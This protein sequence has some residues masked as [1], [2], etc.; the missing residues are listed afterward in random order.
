MIGY[1]CL[2]LLVA[3]VGSFYIFCK[4][5][6]SY[7]SAKGITGPKP[8]P[9][10]G[11]Y[12]RVFLQKQFVNE[13]INDIYLQ[14]P[15]ERVVGLYRG[16]QPV[17]LV[18]DPQL[19]KQIFIKDF[20]DFQDRDTSTSGNKLSINLFTA[21]GNQWKIMRHKLTPVFTSKK[22][23][24][25]VPLILQ[26]GN[27]FVKYVDYLI[28]N[29]I[30]SEIRSLSGKY[31]LQVIASCAFGLD[32][33]TF[34]DENS[35]FYSMAKKIFSQAP[36][37]R[38]IMILDMIIPGLKRRL[39][40]N[41]EIQEFFV[42]LVRKV[43][44]E[45]ENKPS[46]RK[47]FMDLL[48]ELRQQNMN[49]DKAEIVID[50]YMMAAQVIVFYSA[51]FDTSAAVLSFLLYE[52]AMHQDVQDRVYNNIYQAIDKHNG[53]INY[54]TIK[55]MTYLETVLN[56]SLRKHP[57]GGLFTRVA[58]TNYEF[59][60][61]GLT[62]PKGTTIMASTMGMSYD[63]KYFSNPEKFNPDNFAPEN[64]LRLPQCTF[65]PFGE[66]PRNCIGFRFAK[67]Q[68]LIGMAVFLMSFKVE[69][70]P[71]TKP[72]LEYEPK[73][74]VLQASGGIWLKISRR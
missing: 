36:W 51:G 27:Q 74:R 4:R 9:V 50:E 1:T 46:H 68:L 21:R 15:T 37:I 31:T 11:N 73:A 54:E 59:S 22:L 63:P 35:I 3:F 49:D 40:K 55:E 28:D 72:Q 33:N 23:K 62:I 24:D 17:L 41:R 58:S 20:D 53:E 32:I 2:T 67:L 30:E 14:Y 69:A 44:K 65:L 39:V 19:L 26:C 57:V 66:G 34:E 52:L 18:R 10:F 16:F 60:D 38:T 8:F 64:S 43:M 6:Y 47:D 61:I 25:M 29:G 45:R 42:G 56:E 13:C 12:V 70:S 48:I 71:K 5:K 7:W